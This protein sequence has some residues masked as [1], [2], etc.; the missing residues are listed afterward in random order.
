MWPYVLGISI[1]IASHLLGYELDTKEALL[2]V[3]IA[4]VLLAAGNREKQS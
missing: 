1:S 4:A 2:V 3:L